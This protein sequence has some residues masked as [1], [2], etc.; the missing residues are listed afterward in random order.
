MEFFRFHICCHLSGSY[1]SCTAGILHSFRAVMLYIAMTDTPLL[2]LL[3]QQG[4]ETIESFTVGAFRFWLVDALTQVDIYSYLVSNGDFYTLMIIFGIDTSPHCDMSSK[5]DFVHFLCQNFEQFSFKKYAMIL[6]PSENTSVPRLLFLK[7]YRAE[8]DGWNSSLQCSTCMLE[9]RDTIHPFTNCRKP[10]DCY[11]NI[12]KRQSASLFASATHALFNLVFNLD[13]FQM[14]K[15]V[16]YQQYLYVVNSNRFSNW[17]LIP[18]EYSSL[19]VQFRY[20]CPRHTL[21]HNCSGS[22]S[23]N[24][25]T[26]NVYHMISYVVSYLVNLQP[27]HRHWY[28]FYEKSLLFGS[29]CLEHEMHWKCSLFPNSKFTLQRS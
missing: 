11:C 15:D 23:W 9:Y 25:S 18:P 3:F 24:G 17:K 1:V 10:S 21:H 22:G 28:H 16:T 14:T 5:V 29:S 7:Y 20:C 12:C 6:L 8:S 26:T 4:S 27:K 19:H 2:N 13:R